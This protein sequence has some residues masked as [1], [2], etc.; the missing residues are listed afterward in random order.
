MRQV[1]EHFKRKELRK[2]LLLE[3]RF[4]PVVLEVMYE[5]IKLDAV[6]QFDRSRVSLLWSHDFHR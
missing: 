2:I 1:L 6:M 4:L 5:D 3:K